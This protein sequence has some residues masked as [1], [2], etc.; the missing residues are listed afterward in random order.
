MSEG[1]HQ[2]GLGLGERLRSA[3][4]ARAMS[5]EQAAQALHL[6]ESVLRAL[7]DERFSALGA[8]V[9]VRGHLKSY[10][11]LLGLTEAVVLDG[12]RAADPASEVIPRMT[13]DRE[14]PLRTS[15]GPW[16]IAAVVIVAVLGSVLVY[17][18]QDDVPSGGA[19]GSLRP[20]SAVVTPA[21]ALPAGSPPGAAVGSTP[22]AGSAAGTGIGSGE[23]G[24]PAPP[25]A[26]TGAAPTPAGPPAAATRLTLEFVES[27]WVDISDRNGRLLSGDQP[28]GVRQELSGQP[29]FG[30]VLGNSAG[31]RVAVNGEPYSPPPESLEPGST[32]A[33]FRI[34]GPGD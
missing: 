7:E 3:R 11:R 5:L 2:T 24:S 22:A 13:R 30:V 16:S 9:F 29:P 15:P 27:S 1:S 10:A 4:K 34:G 17:F 21:A 25:P 28:A 33:R 14:M 32:R 8:P 18:L 23:P 31:V 12:Y 19:A 20:Q 6:E 26:D